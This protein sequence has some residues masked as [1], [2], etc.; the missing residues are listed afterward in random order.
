MNMND[1]YHIPAGATPM[2]VADAVIREC[3][4]EGFL[5]DVVFFIN[6]YLCRTYNAPIFEAKLDSVKT[7]DKFTNM[8]DT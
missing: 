3:S 7:T 2:T 4:D 1:L 6:A 5:Q 8:R